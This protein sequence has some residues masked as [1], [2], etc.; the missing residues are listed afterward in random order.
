MSSNDKTNP[1]NIRESFYG[2]A[3][4]RPNEPSL[5]KVK[6]SVEGAGGLKPM[7]NVPAQKN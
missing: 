5:E 6:G 4:L 3:K 2:S 7:P 1:I